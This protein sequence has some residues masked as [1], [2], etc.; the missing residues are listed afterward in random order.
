MGFRVFGYGRASTSA[1]VLSTGQQN[2]VCHDYFWLNKQVK[3]EWA[4]A[5]WGGWFADEAVSRDSQFIQREQG[6]RIIACSKPGDIIIAAKFDRTFVNAADVHN[7][8]RYLQ[9]HHIRI[10]VLDVDI[11]T[12]SPLGECFFKI[13]AALKE[14]EVREIRVRTKAALQHRK[15]I[16][17]PSGRPPLGWKSE[18]YRR[19][20]GKLEKYLVPDYVV[21][22]LC[23]EV[24]RISEQNGHAGG[25][26]TAQILHDMGVKN[27]HNRIWKPHA[28]IRVLDAVR[29]GFPLQNGRLES[30]PIPPDAVRVKLVPVKP[31]A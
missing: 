8:L 22:R 12:T 23:D 30:A 11:D 29:Q 19:A 16:G 6:S 13:M 3:P 17:R 10:I 5:E 15:Q 18:V 1:Q 31:D 2:S 26:K 24:F 20:S 25:R 14:L 28:V 27:F 4:D 7:T 21:R 9:D